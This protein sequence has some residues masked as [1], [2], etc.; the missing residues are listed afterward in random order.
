MKTILT[1][2]L[3]ASAVAAQ[4]RPPITGV[5]HMGVKVSRLA[6]SQTFYRDF[7]GLREVPQADG[8][9]L[10]F[11]NADQYVELLPGLNPAD[12]RLD[13]IALRTADPAGLRTYFKSRG[14][15]LLN[16]R[17]PGGGF[18]VMDRDG[19][20]LEFV[21][22]QSDARRK[23]VDGKG[24][25]AR[26]MHL[27]I[28]VGD[29]DQA[30]AFYGGLLGFTEFWR[31]AAA[32][33]QTVSWINVKLPESPDYLE[34]MLYSTLPAPTQRGSQHHICL[35][36]DN[37]D[38]AKSRLEASTYFKTYGKTLEIRTGINRRRQLN[39]FD[40]DGTRIE[41]MEARTVDGFPPKSTTLPLPV[42]K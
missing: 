8:R 38:Q 19:H 40:P 41:L 14:V 29:A 42:R 31:G 9:I 12:D 1:L 20:R 25:S 24:I 5:S 17:F 32:N 16:D 13:H 37:L 11:I 36:V 7:L 2:L 3:I 18:G 15:S 6:A 22:Q 4:T 27:G 21:R 39:L 23:P 10:Y 34:Y 30:M 26:I 28:I 33:S 35:E